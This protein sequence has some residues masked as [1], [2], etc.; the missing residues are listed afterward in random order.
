MQNSKILFQTLVPCCI[1]KLKYID[2]RDDNDNETASKFP[3]NSHFPHFKFAQQSSFLVD[4]ISSTIFF[5]LD[6]DFVQSDPIH[7]Y[8]RCYK[9]IGKISILCNPIPK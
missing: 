4:L 1:F 6:S 2:E 5:H 9:K 8:L 7:K 3:L